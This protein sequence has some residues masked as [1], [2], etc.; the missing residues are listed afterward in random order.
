[1]SRSLALVERVPREQCSSDLTLLAD[2]QDMLQV[3]CF[4]HFEVTRSRQPIHDWRRDKAKTLLKHL[5]AHH[6]RMQ[7]DVLL[8][9]L[10]PELEFETAVRNLRVTLH[11]LRRAL[12]RGSSAESTAFVLARD[13]AIEIK[14]DAR[15]W[16]DTD[17]FNALYDRATLL[18]RRGCR[19]ESLQAY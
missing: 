4:G 13:G 18:W 3:Y 17:S 8:E 1:M 11:A 9:V 6:G 12:G 2:G 7:R 5:I 15:I 14:P 19:E 16:V 10:W